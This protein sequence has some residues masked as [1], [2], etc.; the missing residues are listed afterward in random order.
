MPFFFMPEKVLRAEI[1]KIRA[2]AA[3]VRAEGRS[4]KGAEIEAAAGLDKLHTTEAAAEA[5]VEWLQHDERTAREMLKACDGDV[6]ALMGILN[7]VTFPV[8]KGV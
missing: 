5:F 3:Y 2:K 8:T 7:H 1:E 4:M 6:D